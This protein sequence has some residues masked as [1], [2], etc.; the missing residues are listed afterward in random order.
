[1]AVP[2]QAQFRL[3]KLL[4]TTFD[5]LDHYLKLVNEGK[6]LMEAKRFA[7]FVLWNLQPIF[8]SLPGE[9]WTG[10][11]LPGRRLVPKQLEQKYKDLV[12]ALELQWKSDKPK[13]VPTFEMREIEK[14]HHKL[15]LLAGEVAKQHET[16]KASRSNVGP[17]SEPQRAILPT[18]TGAGSREAATGP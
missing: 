11:E 9:W 15:D 17:S 13:C 5:E 10:P 3:V 2:E 7:S 4:R 8:D 16:L 12:W 6:S 14:L 1:M 18:L